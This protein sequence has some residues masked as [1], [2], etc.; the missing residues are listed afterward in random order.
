[1]PGGE[2]ARISEVTEINRALGAAVLLVNG[3]LIDEVFVSARGP[4]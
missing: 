2:G 3:A 4:K 1:M